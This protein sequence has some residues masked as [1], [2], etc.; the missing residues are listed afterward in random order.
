MIVGRRG[1]ADDELNAVGICPSLTQKLSNGPR[2]HVRSTA[3]LLRLED[4]AG[5][6]ANPLHYPFIAGIY[7]P[8]HLFVVEDVVG[9]VSAHT[10]YDGINLFQSLSL[11]L[12]GY[13]AAI[14]TASRANSV[15][16]VEL[17]AVRT[18]CQ[19]GSYCL[20]VSSSLE[21]PGLGLSSFWMCHNSIYYLIIYDLVFTSS[22]SASHLGSLSFS[23]SIEVRE[24]QSGCT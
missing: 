17:A 3:A 1:G 6:D 2:H 20:V 9:H 15:I 4:V 23:S 22:L 8:R 18:Y 10:S 11:F 16:D 5:F 21:S 14:V 13:L 7:N 12:D 19:C 24:G